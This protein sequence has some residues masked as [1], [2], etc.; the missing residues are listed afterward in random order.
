MPIFSRKENSR[1]IYLSFHQMGERMNNDSGNG[2]LKISEQSG[3]QKKKQKNIFS[4]TIATKFQSRIPPSIIGHCFSTA[5]LTMS[6]STFVNQFN[7]NNSNNL[8]RKLPGTV[9]LRYIA[10]TDIQI[11]IYTHMRIYIF[12]RINKFQIKRRFS[13]QRLLIY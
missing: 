10:Y 7:L 5:F 4:E 12:D 11:Y 6:K 9:H 3:M 13:R 8:I 1:K 2:K